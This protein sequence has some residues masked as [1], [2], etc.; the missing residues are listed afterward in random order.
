MVK[1]PSVSGERLVRALKRT[2]FVVLRQKGSHVSLERKGSDR[3]YRN[4]CADA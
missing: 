2:G 3:V 1:L 4:H